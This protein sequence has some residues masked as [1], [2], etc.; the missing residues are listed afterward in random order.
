[1][2]IHQY[3]NKIEYVAD[4]LRKLIGSGAL[5]AGARLKSSAELAAELNVSPM[6]ADRAIRQLTA[7]GILKRVTGSGTFVLERGKTINICIVDS[8]KFHS[9]LERDILY[10]ENTFPLLEK[11]FAN[12]NA[13]FQ[14]VKSWDL[15][16]N[17]NP[18]GILSATPPPEGMRLT[19]PAAIYR[20]YKLFEGPYIQSVP[21]LN[22][23]MHDIC[24]RLVQ[25]KVR[26]I[27]VFATPHPPINYF[28]KTFMEHCKLYDLQDIIEYCEESS[29]KYMP[30]TRLG[31]EYA[32]RLPIKKNTAIFTTSD[33]RAAGILKALDKRNISPRDYDLI[34]CNNWED[35]GYLPFDVPR[36]TSID[37]RRRECLCDVIRQLCQAI[38]EPA[39]GRI[40]VSKY[41]ALL[42]I[43]ESGLKM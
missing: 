23:V 41:P 40:T 5:P 26:R 42:K 16:D 24:S 18:D 27:C 30:P 15:L 33:F 4:H 2:L 38:R 28:A 8:K 1:M 36:I 13:R 32:I 31:F 21:D 39:N 37:L 17:L 11:E 3:K 20:N 12:S 7:E 25:K 10:N 22:E 14:Y 43:R 35:Y 34:S 29:H 9:V 19:V 6:T